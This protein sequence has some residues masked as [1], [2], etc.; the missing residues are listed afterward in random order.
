M[1]VIAGVTSAGLLF[2]FVYSQGP[3]VARVSMLEAGG[4]MNLTVRGKPGLSGAYAIAEDG[5]IALPG[6]AAVNVAGLSAKAAADR[7]AESL[8][9]PQ[10]PE[11]EASVRVETSNILAIFPV[12]AVGL[13]GGALINVFYPAYRMTRNKSWD[14]LA[15]SWREVLLAAIIGIQ[16][17]ISVVLC[18]KGMVLLGVLGASVGAGIQQAMQMT[19]GQGVGFVSGEWGGVRGTPRR[20]MAVAIALLLVATAIMAASN[21]LAN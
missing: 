14:V 8:H 19:G 15:S 9:L 10:Q 12:W 7:V 18:G 17:C 2:A 20:Q 4:K 11:A 13:L 3:I 5:T 6:Q 21:T 16:F 1:V